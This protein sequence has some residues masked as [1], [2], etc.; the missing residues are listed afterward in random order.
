MTDP[1]GFT[2]YAID[3]ALFIAGWCVLALIIGL[4]YV[5]LC[6]LADRRSREEREMREFLTAVGRDA[7][8][9][10]TAAMIA[11]ADELA[12]DVRNA[13]QTARLAGTIRRAPLV[14]VEDID[15]IP[16]VG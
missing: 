2:A 8:R 16:Q 11:N 4:L 7:R 12:R 6:R 3:T 10:H 5:R 14:A 13:R 15:S 9:A 1:V